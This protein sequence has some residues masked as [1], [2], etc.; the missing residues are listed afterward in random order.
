MAV[1]CGI[2]LHANY[3]VV[4]VQEDKDHVVYKRRLQNDIVAIVQTL[5]PFKA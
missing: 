5:R 3:S 2:E 1:Y 4:V